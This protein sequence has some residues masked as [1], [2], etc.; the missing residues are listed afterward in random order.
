MPRGPKK[1][2]TFDEQINALD[3]KIAEAEA[4]IKNYK[5]QKKSLIETKE[6]EEL[7][8]VIEIFKASGKT[9]EEI[10]ALLLA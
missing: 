4:K 7:K 1:V 3:I 2:I 9:I 5:D 8:E 6:K 10:K